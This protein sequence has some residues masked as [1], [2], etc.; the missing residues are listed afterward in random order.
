M[1]SL[2]GNFLEQI[3]VIGNFDSPNSHN[4]SVILI[5]WVL[6]YCQT[7]FGSLLHHEMLTNQETLTRNSF[8]LYVK[9]ETLLTHKVELG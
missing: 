4:Q 5:H 7:V 6:L 2:C 1:H 3:S 9:E 8:R